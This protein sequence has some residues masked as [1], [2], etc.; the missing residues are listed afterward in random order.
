MDEE[1]VLK[2][3]KASVAL[4]KNADT[5]FD[6]KAA[7][8]KAKIKVVRKRPFI[9]D[10]TEY[11]YPECGHNVRFS[12]NYKLKVYIMDCPECNATT[13]SPSKWEK[14]TAKSFGLTFDSNVKLKAS[15]RHEQL[16][17]HDFCGR[18]LQLDYWAAKEGRYNCP[19]CH[20]HSKNRPSWIYL[21]M[22]VLGGNKWLKLGKA[23]DVTARSKQ[24]GL[25]PDAVI[26]EIFRTGFNTGTEALTREGVVHDKFKDDKISQEEAKA[27]G[28]TC[29]FTECYPVSLG[30]QLIDELIRA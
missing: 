19:N 25:H 8:Q 20:Q 26:T 16:Y 7:E 15:H 4:Y 18:Q 5:V 14:E 21:F 13:R 1:I 9:A 10:S 24:Y 12:S 17:I 3:L 23:E 22:I 11:S 30:E 2:D 27:F 6:Y 28:M 29:G